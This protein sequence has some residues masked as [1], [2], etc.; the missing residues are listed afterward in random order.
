[1]TS[2][3]EPSVDGAGTWPAG[4][5]ALRCSV[6]LR[7]GLLPARAI[8]VLAD[9]DPGGTGAAAG[10]I[11][12]RIA[13]GQEPPVA[14]A[15]ENGPDWRY[16]AG[17][18]EA[19][20][21]SGAPLSDSL[22]RLAEALDG[23]RRLADRRDVLLSGPRATVRL[24]A[25]LPVL[26]LLLG[27]LLGFDPLPVLFGPIGGISAVA[28]AGL[29]WA[30]I[31]WARALADRELGA[32]RIAGLEL[33]LLGI[34]AHGGAGLRAGIRRAADCAD[35]HRAEWV[36]L[37]DLRGASGARRALESAAETGIAFG[38][39]L[40]RFA[41]ERR[42]S[43]HAALERS[44]ERLGVRILV[45]LAVCVLPAFVLLGVVPVLIAVLG[46]VLESGR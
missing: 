42:E 36:R 22:A 45:P 23:L 24:V 25:A 10:R 7:G 14:I 26:A 17:A 30:G 40:L 13:L 2:V 31:V 6:L 44:A 29:L 9:T 5:F 16:L 8:E 43:A 33:E 39:V 19:A 12:D 3:G 27:I 20:G 46:G 28:G 4:E 21:L 15:A 41:A 18:W 32:E 1:M 34:A 35:R 11:S 37:D 38:D